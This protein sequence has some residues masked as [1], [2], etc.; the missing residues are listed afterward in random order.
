MILDT[1]MMMLLSFEDLLKLANWPL[2]AASFLVSVRNDS[3]QNGSVRNDNIFRK[4]KK[5]K[6][7]ILFF[8]FALRPLQTIL[9]H[10]PWSEDSKYVL[11]FKLGH[12]EVGQKIGVT[13]RRDTQTDKH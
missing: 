10:S 11:E 12:Q 8:I 7:D 3:V 6:T 5:V 13:F 2:S 4:V 1:L 9:L